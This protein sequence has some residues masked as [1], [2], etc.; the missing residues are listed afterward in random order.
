[1]IIVIADDLTGAAEM[2]GIAWC[3]HMHVE[4]IIYH[5]HTSL[6]HLLS[7]YP[8]V[9]VV[10]TDNRSVSAQQAEINTILFFADISW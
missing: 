1:M 3:H 7:A 9:L 2:A 5:S 8:D 6:P 10:A 4:M